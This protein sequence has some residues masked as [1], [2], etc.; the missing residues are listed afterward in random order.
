MYEIKPTVRIQFLQSYYHCWITTGT[1][2]THSTWQ[3]VLK[4]SASHITF[5]QTDWTQS[6]LSCASTNMMQ[7]VNRLPPLVPPL[8]LQ[9]DVTGL[10]KL[11]T[12]KSCH[13]ATDQVS[14]RG[15]QRNFFSS[16]H[17]ALENSTDSTLSLGSSIHFR[18]ALSLL[19][20]MLYDFIKQPM[21]TMTSTTTTTS[22]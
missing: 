11:S 15:G 16:S 14:C 7:I 21:W 18:I 2:V 10:A 20:T 12:A 13:A 8:F 6:F 9:T 1:F 5:S 22:K 3:A 19:R 17:W 4:Q